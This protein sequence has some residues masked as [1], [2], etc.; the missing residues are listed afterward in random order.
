MK[1]GQILPACTT[2]PAEGIDMAASGEELLLL[3][4]TSLELL[5]SDRRAGD[6]RHALLS[7]PC[8]LRTHLPQ[9]SGR[10]RRNNP[11][12]Q[13]RLILDA[14]QAA[15]FAKAPSNGKKIAAN[16]SS[17]SGLAIACELTGRGYEV[18][19]AKPEDEFLTP[20][21]EAG[22]ALVKVVRYEPETLE[23]YGIRMLKGVLACL[24][25]FRKKTV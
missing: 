20:Y 18:I 14:S 2:L 24:K 3:R 9:K 8:A 25:H 22:K 16:N 5:L 7:L 13:K 19:A 11:R 23:K 12:R 1:T 21:I 6:S 17:Q 15:V 4:R 10:C